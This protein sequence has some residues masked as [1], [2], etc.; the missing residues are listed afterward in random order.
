MLYMFN[1]FSCYFLFPA[2]LSFNLL[3]LICE[4]PSSF[5]LAVP[6]LLPLH[7]VAGTNETT[8]QAYLKHGKWCQIVLLFFA[9]LVM[10]QYFFFLKRKGIIVART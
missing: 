3:V 4:T 2:C 7:Q 8:D 1:M 9:M 10:P 6:L 5:S